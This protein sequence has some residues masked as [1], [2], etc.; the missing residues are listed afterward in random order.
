LQAIESVRHRLRGLA[1][2]VH[3]YRS[4][5]ST[6]DVAMSLAAAGCVGA[7]VLA[8]EQTAGRGRRG[9][10]WFSPPGSGLYVSVVL[11]PGRAQRDPVRATML[12]TLAAG[13]ALSEGIEVSTGLRVDLKWPN[14]LYVAQRKLA[15]ILAEASGRP[16]DP[17][18][19]GYGINVASSAFPP[20]L[21]ERATSLE[22]ELGRPTDRFLVFAETVAALAT[23]Y[24][25]LLAGRFDAILDAW[26]RRAPRATGARVSWTDSTGTRSG[27]TAGI[28]EDGALLVRIDAR[29]GQI[30]RIVSGQLTWLPC[31]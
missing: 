22:S 1:S 21:C 2:L 26:R 20:D 4:T 13:V 9:H 14:D 24:D 28:D 10:T 15:G 16:P 19:V 6:N 18:V 8:D 31:S 23:R 17:V 11:A 5:R 30:E 25:D 12:L 29:P 7:V 27:V 3:F